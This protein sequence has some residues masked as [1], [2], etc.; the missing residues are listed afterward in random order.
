MKKKKKVW[1]IPHL[2]PSVEFSTIS[3][4]IDDDDGQGSFRP[5]IKNYSGISF[6]AS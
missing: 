6:K 2:G 1:K 4:F 5:W 3:F